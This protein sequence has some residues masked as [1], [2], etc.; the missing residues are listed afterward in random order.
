MF[1]GRLDDRRKFGRGAVWQQ[2]VERAVVGG[3]IL[4]SDALQV[5]GGDAFDGGQVA[6][7]EIQVIGRK[8]T[9]AQVLCL[10]GHGLARGERGGDELLDRFIEFRVGNGLF[11]EFPDFAQ[12]GVSGFLELVRIK[13]RT[14]AEQTGLAGIVGPGIHVIDQTLLFPHFLK[15]PG[16]ATVAQQ[17]GQHVKRRNIRMSQG[18]DVPRH[19]EMAQLN[20]GFLDDLAGCGLFRFFRQGHR[21]N[22]SGFVVLVSFTDL[23]ND[24]AGFYITRNHVK[25]VIRSVLAMVEI[26]DVLLLHFIVDVRITDN[27]IAVGAARVGRFE[28]TATR[29]A[30]GVILVHIHFPKDNLFFLGHFVGRQRSVL[31]DVAKDVNGRVGTGV[32]R[33]NVKHRPVERCVS[34]HVTAGLLDFLINAAA[35]AGG[36]ALEEHVLEHVSQA[37]AQPFAFVDA[38]GHAPRLGRDNRRAV[39]FAN[40]D[41]QA[42]VQRGEGGAGRQRGDLRLVF[43]EGSGGGN[44]NSGKGGG[45][46]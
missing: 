10:A 18:G 1:R 8:P 20:R 24:L 13:D 16:T 3:E 17:H 44:H 27:G 7:G 32:G 19:V 15:E 25:H 42:V 34:V 23:G 6:F 31:H 39:I 4:S 2:R 45:D 46:S 28:Q 33:V 5:G 14:H 26:E 29:A 43:G 21:G 9:A 37:G 38:A 35:A 41:L 22:R 12:D 30:T 40:D 11:L 36:G